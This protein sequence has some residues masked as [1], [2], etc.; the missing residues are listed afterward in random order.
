MQLYIFW[1]GRSSIQ[2]KV[3]TAYL[4]VTILNISKRSQIFANV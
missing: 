1:E 2:V 4:I 3:Y